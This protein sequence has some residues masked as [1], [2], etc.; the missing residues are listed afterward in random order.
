M[1]KPDNTESIDGVTPTFQ[2]NRLFP[3]ITKKLFLHFFFLA[4]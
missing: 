2:V 1:Y 4:A 3:F